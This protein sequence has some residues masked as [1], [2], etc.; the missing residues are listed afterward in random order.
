MKQKIIL[1]LL[2]VVW[3]S[4]CTS[5]D[6][7]KQHQQYLSSKGW[8]IKN[9]DE[10]EQT[11]LDIPTEI[12]DN[13]ESSGVTFLR[14]YNG[15]EVTI[16]SYSLKEK[17]AEGERLKAYIYEVEDEIIGGYGVLSSWSPGVFS[18]DDQSR[19]LEKEMIEK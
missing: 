19:L 9:L 15:K 12:L 17:D 14:E 8:E 13:Y 18:L 16:Y 1:L 7:N 3:L 4:G 6:I 2:G 5:K 10:V 11:I